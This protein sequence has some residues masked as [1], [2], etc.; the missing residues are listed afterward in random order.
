MRALDIK[1]EQLETV[2]QR[3]LQL[4]GVMN[5][6]ADGRGTLKDPGLKSSD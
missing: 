1:L 3:N 4:T 2:K 5:V 6:T